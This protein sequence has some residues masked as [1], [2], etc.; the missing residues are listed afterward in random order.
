M[1]LDAKP[2]VTTPTIASNDANGSSV[3]RESDVLTASATAG[4][5]DNTVSY[6]WYY[7]NDLNH[8]IGT[9]ATYTVKEG[10]ETS[11]I[12]VKATATNDDSSASTSATSAATATVTDKAPSI[13]VAINGTAQ[14]GQTLSA[15]VSGADSD[16]ALTYQWQ[17]SSDG[18]HSSNIANATS[19]SYAVQEGDEGNQLKLI[20]TDTADNNGGTAT[21]NAT[22][23]T[24]TDITPQLSVTATGT[25]QEGQTPTANPV[26]NDSDAMVTYQW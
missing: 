12:V 16:D 21:A 5:S 11:Q 10:D 17:S 2:T 9:G 7:A 14:E 25:A 3:V 6:T 4:H 8:A 24:V 23:G 15:V 18:T 20:V 19:S 1:V 26:A 13:T 22:S